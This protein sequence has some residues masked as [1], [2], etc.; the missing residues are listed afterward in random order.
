MSHDKAF[1]NRREM[2]RRKEM[3]RNEKGFMRFNEM[4]RMLIMKAF[5]EYRGEEILKVDIDFP[6]EAVMDDFLRGMDP[7]LQ[8]AS[9]AGYNVSLGKRSGEITRLD[10]SKGTALQ[11]VVEMYGGTLADAYAF[12]DS[13]NDL[14]MLRM[15]GTGIAMGN[16]FAEVK[17]V[18]DYVTA[19]IDEDGIAKA[20]R[21]FGLYE[22]V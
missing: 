4:V 21:H 9:T 14:E 6:S 17:A 19:P 11:K 8:L 18:A 15:A 22:E 5:T 13:G 2:E 12:G 7:G 10:V 16:G 1:V 3:C 20:M